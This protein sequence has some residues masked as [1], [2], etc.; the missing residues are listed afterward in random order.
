MGSLLGT[1]LC[2]QRTGLLELAI[3]FVED[4]LFPAKQFVQRRNVTQR[5]VQPH[6]VVFVDILR[7]DAPCILQRERR[8]R[9]NTLRLDRAVIAFQLAI[10]LRIVRRRLHVGHATDTNEV[11]K[12]LGDELRAI[13]R[14]DPRRLP[15]MFFPG[16]LQDCLHIY[17]FH[18]LADFP[19]HDGAAIAV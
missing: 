8:L 3:S 15:R 7:D 13:V 1:S 6:L 11:F 5:A 12:F 2:P 4:L 10:A 19:V 17:L 9:T 16:T 14:D 18:L